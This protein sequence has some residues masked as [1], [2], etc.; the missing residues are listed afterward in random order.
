MMSA[1]GHFRFLLGVALSSL[2]QIHCVP[3]RPLMKLMVHRVEDHAQN[4][5]NLAPHDARDW[6]RKTM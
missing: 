2:G 5:R 3:N 1:P 6:Q 4:L